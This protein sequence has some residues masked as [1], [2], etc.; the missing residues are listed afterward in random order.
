M[1]KSL[2]SHIIIISSIMV[3]ACVYHTLYSV[4]AVPTVNTVPYKLDQTAP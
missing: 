1:C 3:T 4:H 2:T